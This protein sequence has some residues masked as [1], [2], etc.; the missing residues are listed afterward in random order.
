MSRHSRGKPTRH[1]RSLPC[2]SPTP[3]SAFCASLGSDRDSVTL[4]ETWLTKVKMAEARRNKAAR[5]I[6]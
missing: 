6:A 2:L 4:P 3:P 5:S 1:T